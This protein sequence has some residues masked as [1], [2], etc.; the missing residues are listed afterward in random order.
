MSQGIYLFTRFERF[1]HWTQMLL[2]LGLLFTGSA[3]HGWHGALTFGAAMDAHVVLAWALI[4][5]WILAIFWHLTT[6]EWKQ[7]VPT[8]RG[9]MAMVL[10]YGYKIFSGEP[11]PYT[12]TPRAKH[13]PLQRLAYLGFKTFIAPLL[14]ISGL[15]LL[16]SGAWRATGLGE[17]LPF[18]WVAWAHVAGAYLLVVFLIGHVYMAA[19]TGTPWYAHLRAMVTGY[20]GTGTERPSETGADS[21]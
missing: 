11:K 6:G 5:L 20:E 19:T 2:I 9:L 4:G 13:N 21:A 8:H 12:T 15:L 1:W 18:A 7:Y 10:Y 17:I 14:W 3:L 16:F